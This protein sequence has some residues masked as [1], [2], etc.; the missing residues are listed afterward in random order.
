VKLR[1]V[2]SSFVY[3]FKDQQLVRRSQLKANL[4]WKPNAKTIAG[5]NGV[6]NK[7]NQLKAPHGIY[8]DYIKQY[9]YIAD[10]GNH[11]ILKWKLGENNGQIVAGENGELNYPVDVIVD[12]NNKDLIICDIGNRRVIRWSLENQQINKIIVD[13]IKC[14][15]LMIN[16]NG[17]LFV[18]DE[19]RN[20][21]KRWRK[22]E[23]GEGIIVAN[24]LNHPIFIFVDRQ[25]TIYVSDSWNHRVMKW[26]KDAKEGTVVAGGHGGGGSLNQLAYPYGLTVNEVGDV[27][28]AD[29]GNS[30][31]MCWSP[32]SDEGRVVVGGNGDG[33][34]SNQ[35]HHLRELSFDFENNL[36]V[37]DYENHRIQ[38]FEVDQ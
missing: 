21:V 38:Q 34:G 12:E 5:E 20:E 8:V 22:G 11:R 26:A 28:V 19:E 37:I 9:I 14:F 29:S 4:K 16:E 23:Q 30:R 33:Q 2:S 3:Y 27:F 15:G 18:S 35:F 25:E 36:Y 13:N 7:T 10:S 24:Q 31:I 1:S 6:G 32:G 17:D